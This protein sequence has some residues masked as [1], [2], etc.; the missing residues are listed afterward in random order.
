MCS[1]SNLPSNR[2]C[3][4]PPWPATIRIS[5][6]TAT[7]TATAQCNEA[8]GRTHTIAWNPHG[9]L[10]VLSSSSS[11]LSFHRFHT[12]AF[13]L[14]RTGYILATPRFLSLSYIHLAPFLASLASLV[15]RKIPYDYR[16]YYQ[17]LRLPRLQ[18]AKFNFNLSFDTR[19]CSL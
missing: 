14:G 16:Y 9:L 15:I 7:S 5:P 11:S 18:L 12:R 4:R 2:P 6:Q 10:S 17:L 3:S 13:G 19:S 8:A 1:A